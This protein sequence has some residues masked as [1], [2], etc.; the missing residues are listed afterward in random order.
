MTRQLLAP[1]RPTNRR[2]GDDPSARGLSQVYC[3]CPLR[4]LRPVVC[5]PV[6]VRS[7]RSRSWPTS[8]HRRQRSA[9]CRPSRSR[10]TP[11]TSARPSNRGGPHERLRRSSPP[12]STCGR[13]SKTCR[14]VWL[15]TLTRVPIVRIS[16]RAAGLTRRASSLPARS[17]Y[18]PRWTRLQRGEQTTHHL[19]LA[20]TFKSPMRGQ[21][22]GGPP[23][24][25]P[26][27][28][29]PNP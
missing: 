9:S 13:V 6:V 8:R 10:W 4:V 27:V 3:S 17:G 15:T 2:P 18:F 14:L 29:P 23:V 16:A 12:P 22:G 24:A 5:A 7:T 19:H 25:H 1:E 21:E 11:S 20:A 28:G 26:V